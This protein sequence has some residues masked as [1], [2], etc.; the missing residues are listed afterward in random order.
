MLMGTGGRHTPFVVGCVFDEVDCAFV[1]EISIPS[2]IC[3][4]IYFVYPIDIANRD[5]FVLKRVGSAWLMVPFAVC[6]LNHKM[7]IKLIVVIFSNANKMMMR[8]YIDIRHR[9]GGII[10]GVSKTFQIVWDP[11]RHCICI[12]VWV[13]DVGIEVITVMDPF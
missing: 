8:S 6:F 10:D 4:V 9:C 3:T 2:I 5:K 12:C 7:E 1:G 13:T 11:Q